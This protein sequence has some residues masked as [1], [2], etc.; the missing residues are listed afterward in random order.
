MSQHR[1]V[2][3]LF[4]QQNLRLALNGIKIFKKPEI[5]SDSGQVFVPKSA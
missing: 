4:L 1:P 3:T 2:I 5:S